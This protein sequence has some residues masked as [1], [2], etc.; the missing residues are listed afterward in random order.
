[1]GETGARDLLLD[2]LVEFVVVT[3]VEELRWGAFAAGPTLERC[4]SSA[5][6]LCT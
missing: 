6:S 3:A 2:E 5:Y 4:M 1:M